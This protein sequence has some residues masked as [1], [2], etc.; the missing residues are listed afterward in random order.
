M[1]REVDSLLA[2]FFAARRKSPSLDLEALEM[3]TRA[4]LH[5]VGASVLEELLAAS[6][7]IRPQ[8][9]CGC[10]PSAGYHERRGK[11]LVTVLGRVETERAYY[12]CPHCHQGQSPRDRELDVEGT[13]YSPGVRRMMAMVGS[14]ASFEQ[15]REQLALLAGLEVTS[16]A[17]ERQAEA[18]GADIAAQ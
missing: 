4:A 14:E 3:A 12:L 5:R 7:E 2:V 15:G 6:E 9:P 13:E 8:V 10:G 18:I 17:P 1:A 11:Q 16:K